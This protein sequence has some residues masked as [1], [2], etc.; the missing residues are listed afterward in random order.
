MTRNRVLR[1]TVH[2]VHFDVDQTVG[3]TLQE[4]RQC[5]PSLRRAAST[6]SANSSR[7]IRDLRRLAP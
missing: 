3:E 6:Y 7:A 1:L 5:I 2:Q 4:F